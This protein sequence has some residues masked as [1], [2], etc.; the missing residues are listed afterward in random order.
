MRGLTKRLERRIFSD[1]VLPLIARHSDAPSGGHWRGAGGGRRRGTAVDAQVSRLAG[2]GSATRQKASMLKLTRI[3]FAALDERGLEPVLGQ[4]AV[5]SVFHRIGTAADVIC[6]KADANELVVVE[7]KCGHS[8]GRTAA[9]INK[10]GTCKMRGPLAGADDCVLN[11]H[12]SQLAVTTAL[13]KRETRTMARL[14]ALGIEC[15][16][17]LLVYANDERCDVYK[18]PEWWL[19]KADRILGALK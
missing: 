16:T 15:V 5:A 12:F 7:L 13:L 8:Q 11:R 2:V 10:S 9:A 4:R 14:G 19:R 1:G 6:H 18:M 17:A 3:V